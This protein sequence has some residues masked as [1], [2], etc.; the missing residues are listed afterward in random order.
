MQIVNGTVQGLELETGFSTS[1]EIAKMNSQLSFLTSYKWEIGDVNAFYVRKQLL[2]DKRDANGNRIP[3]KGSASDVARQ[4]CLAE[5]MA[6]ADITDTYLFERFNKDTDIQALSEFVRPILTK[7]NGKTMTSRFLAKTET[8]PV[9]GKRIKSTL[10]EVA[11]ITS[12]IHAELRKTEEAKLRQ[13]NIADKMIKDVLTKYDSDNKLIRASKIRVAMEVCVFP[14]D[15]VTFKIKDGTDTER[16]RGVIYS[17]SFDTYSK[18]KERLHTSNDTHLDFL[19]LKITHPKAETKM[20]SGLK[21]SFESF[22][23]TQSPANLITNFTENYNEYCKTAAQDANDLRAKVMDYREISDEELLSICKDYV[24]KNY[25][26][27]SEEERKKHDAIV[28]RFQEVLTAEEI[29]AI[30][31]VT[32]SASPNVKEAEGMNGVAEDKTGDVFSGIDD[33]DDFS[34]E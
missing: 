31:N 26:L 33:D 22:D 7:V 27:L 17:T 5:G 32:F 21:T 24:I 13:A 2:S 25:N 6:E 19:E 34:L 3:Y 28:Q 12:A 10:D 8:D 23:S 11:G 1:S 16:F 30:S 4:I 15:P 18:L 9:T 29:A 20:Q 14:V